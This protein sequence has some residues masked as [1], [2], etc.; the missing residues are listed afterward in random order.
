MQALRDAVDDAHVGLMRDEDVDVVEREA[1]LGDGLLG[2]VGHRLHGE[3][4]DLAARHRD[5][6]LTP[7]DRV[8]R[9][10]AL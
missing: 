3:L 7:F 5:E 10:R 2:G 9:G 6:V 4:E 8:G 1:G